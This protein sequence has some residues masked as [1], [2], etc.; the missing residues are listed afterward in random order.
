MVGHVAIE[1]LAVGDQVL[2]HAAAG[3]GR[4]DEHENARAALGGDVD[5]RREAV[6]AQV[7]ADGEGVGAPGAGFA[8][9]IAAA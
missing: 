9:E 5:E 8:A 6:V 4:F 2:K 7:G 3:I 1:R